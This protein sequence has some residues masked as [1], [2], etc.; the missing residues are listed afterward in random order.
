MNA[1]ISFILAALFAVPTAVAPAEP[2]AYAPQPT[3]I[4]QTASTQKYSL[5]GSQTQLMS[6]PSWPCRNFGLFCK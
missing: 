1:L 6:G 5:A 3:A 2:P 4:Q